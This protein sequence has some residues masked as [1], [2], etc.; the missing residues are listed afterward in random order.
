MNRILSLIGVV[1]VVGCGGP[2]PRD[3]E[4][5]QELEPRDMG[6]LRGVDGLYLNPED[7]QPYSGP[8]FGENM[9]KRMTGSLR[10]GKWDGPFES[11]HDNGQL[12]RKGTY[13]DGVEDGPVEEYYDSGQLY[14]KGAYNDGG[15]CGEWFEGKT[16]TYDPC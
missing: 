15:K 8:V 11:Y 13:K 12:R 9:G 1:L 10:D 3:M 16:V 6:T 14:E 7:G 5:L 4:T 2:E